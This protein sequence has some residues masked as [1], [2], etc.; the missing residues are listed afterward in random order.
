MLDPSS[1]EVM[2]PLLKRPSVVIMENCGHAPMLERPEET[3]QHYQAFLDA[4]PN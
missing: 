1:I 4:N 3:A 2:K